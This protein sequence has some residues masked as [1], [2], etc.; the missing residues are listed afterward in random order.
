MAH[1]R[2]VRGA[3]AEENSE[4]K[5]WL[6]RLASGTRHHYLVHFYAYFR[7]LQENG[8]EFSG[9]SV[10]ELL[11]LQDRAVGR[12]RFKQLKM[13]QRYVSER[14]L[15]YSTKM[16]VYSV[17]RSF[18]AHNYVE[19][20][21]D[22]TFKVH[23]DIPESNGTLDVDGLKRILGMAPLGYR[24]VFLCM[25]Q[26]GMGEG[27]FEIFNMS[28]NQVK[29]HLEGNRDVIKVL[30][31]GRKHS[32]NQR[33]YYTLLARSSDTVKALQKYLDVERGAVGE[34]EP[35]FQTKY[36]SK[37]KGANICQMFRVYAERAGLLKRE[38]PKCPRCDGETIRMR[39]RIGTS[40]I[41][42]VFYRCKKCGKN[43]FASEENKLPHTRY[44][45]NPHEM[46]DV[47]RSEWHLSRADPD[48]AEFMM[49]HNVDPNKYD[50]I[51]K[52]HP[53]YAEEE[54]RKALPFLNILTEDPRKVSLDK[55]REIEEKTREIEA[56]K[57]QMAEQQGS[58]KNLERM[59]ADIESLVRQ[60]G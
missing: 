28:W 1:M 8:G 49:G 44:G 59:V 57:R 9:R 27:E 56:L 39:K 18:Y 13:L 46:R 3:W 25:F 53:E 29:T 26:S 6:G 11:D 38:T 12:D 16:D 55:V 21:P 2:A 20:P 14:R 32:K 51:M 40:R 17:V 4:V 54:Y 35:I 43:M 48:V 50:K 33:P 7:W 47:F 52:L 23:S 42:K 5:D 10:G 30:L 24:A 41:Q 19:L 60:K 58:I 15:R 45:L 36:G 37:I 34:G 31:P 22:V